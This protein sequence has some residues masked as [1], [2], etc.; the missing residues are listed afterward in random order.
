MS[1]IT[2]I[3]VELYKELLVKPGNCPEM[4]SINSTCTCSL[5]CVATLLEHAYAVYY[6]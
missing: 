3:N 5:A 2:S 1:T 6:V 4:S